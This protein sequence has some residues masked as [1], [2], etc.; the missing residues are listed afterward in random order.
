MTSDMTSDMDHG[1]AQPVPS[2]LVMTILSFLALAVGV[3]IAEF[4]APMAPM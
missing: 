2:V 3:A 4:A 1:R